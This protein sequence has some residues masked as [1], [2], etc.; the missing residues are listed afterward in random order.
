MMRQTASKACC[1]DYHGRLTELTTLVS[2]GLKE[3]VSMSLPY[4]LYKAEYRSTRTPKAGRTIIECYRRS[5]SAHMKI[6]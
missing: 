1:P 2:N 6:A 5:G 3:A 4:A